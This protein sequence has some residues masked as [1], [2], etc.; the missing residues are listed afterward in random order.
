M[1]TTKRTETAMLSEVQI[2]R[3]GKAE[4][5]EILICKH[6]YPYAMCDVCQAIDE[7]WVRKWEREFRKFD[8]SNE[9]ARGEGDGTLS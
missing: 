5:S 1:E 8:E 6:G 4:M 7:W 2:L 3:M 9:N